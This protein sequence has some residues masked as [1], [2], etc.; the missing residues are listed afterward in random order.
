MLDWTKI[1]NE[2][3]FQNL[4]ND[5]FAWEIDK[6]DFKPG[7]AYIGADGGWDG[8]HDGEYGGVNGTFLFQAKWTSKQDLT[9]AFKSIKSVLPS[10]LEKARDQAVNHVILA[11]NAKLQVGSHIPDLEALNDGHV[12]N[13]FVYDQ[14]KLEQ[15]IDK[16]PWIKY[17]YF[18]QAA[19]PLFSPAEN[20][21]DKSE[22]ELVITKDFFGFK[23]E[24]LQF[25]DFLETNNRILV[26]SAP[27]GCGK[28]RFLHEVT[29]EISE[30]AD[31]PWI[32][33]F[34]RLSL[35]PLDTAFSEELLSDR[36][37][38]LFI[39][40]IDLYPEK[41]P[42]I[43][44]AAKHLDRSRIRIVLTSRTENVDTI[45]KE[46]DRLRINDS[47][48][49]ELESLPAEEQV[50]LLEEVSG[51]SITKEMEKVL[52]GLGDNLHQ[53]V[54]Y[55]V[56]LS[57][58]DSVKAEDI[59]T[60]IIKEQ[61][62]KAGTLQ[63]QGFSENEVN[64]LLV[65]LAANVPFKYS[66]EKSLSLLSSQL[67]KSQEDV[68]RAIKTLEDNGLIRQIG[69]SYRFSTDMKGNILLSQ[70]VSSETLD[71]N[72][73]H[74]WMSIDAK[75]LSY[76]LGIA[77]MHS[78]DAWLHS[79]I[80][81]VV[82][83]L[84]VE[85]GGAE[86]DVSTRGLDW[87]ANF[88]HVVP[89]VVVNCLYILLQKLEDPI[90]RDDLGSILSSLVVQP[91]FNKEILEL[92]RVISNRN[93]D[94][95]YNN[96]EPKELIGDAVSPIKMR[97]ID[98]A[99]QNLALLQEW[100]S[101]DDMS[102]DT[103]ELIISALEEALGGSHKYNHSEG[104][105]ITF[106]HRVLVYGP[107]VEEY[108][109]SAMLVVKKLFKHT[110]NEA[111]IEA[112]KLLSKVGAETHTKE[113]PLWNRI[114][115]DKLE[116]LK[117]IENEILSEDPDI[118]LLSEAEDELFRLW[119]NTDV[120]PELEAKTLELLKVLPKSPELQ[121]YK[122]I[123]NSDFVIKNNADVISEAPD[124]EIWSWLV[125]NHMHRFSATDNDILITVVD[126][127]SK[128]Y[129]SAEDVVLFLQ[130][131]DEKITGTHWGYTPL[132]ETWFSKSKD[133]IIKIISEDNLMQQVP[134]RFVH[135]F[136]MVGSKNIPEYLDEY[137]LSIL[138]KKIVD[139]TELDKL[140]DMIQASDKDPEIYTLWLNDIC[141][142]L[143]ADAKRILINRLPRI[144]EGLSL[145]KKQEMVNILTNV[146][147]SDDEGG[148]AGHADFS[149]HQIERY[150]DYQDLDLVDFKAALFNSL[151]CA[152]RFDYHQKSAASFVL[153]QNIH[154][155]IELI[156]SRLRHKD[157]S[158][159][160]YDALPFD[161]FDDLADYIKSYEEYCLLVEKI[162]EWLTNDLMYSFQV[163][164][165]TSRLHSL[166]D[167]NGKTFNQKYIE[168]KLASK[169]ETDVET[170]IT[171]LHGIVFGL[172]TYGVFITALERTDGTKLYDKAK[173]VL[174]HGVL[175]GSFSGTVG[176]TPKEWIV[177]QSTLEQIIST[178]KPGKT[179]MLFESL[180]NQV[181][182]DI[183]SNLEEAE[184]ILDPKE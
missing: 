85:L 22:Y 16:Y 97:N 109:S 83:S 110:Q 126:E 82:E 43:L 7:N 74:E 44:G 96:Y 19:E 153:E 125:H 61:L 146:L 176:E 65:L 138:E 148:L 39:D 144:Y 36:K 63:S 20:Y 173:N 131:L 81:S 87:L 67:G 42:D 150:L 161:G 71:K 59:N 111:K 15:I 66:D 14:T 23:R 99:I 168:E 1:D 123:S 52:K 77:Y 26:V 91:V 177:K 171:C 21:F 55:G 60:G 105:T 149:V 180:L 156:E 104:V 62:S 179:K 121:I 34:G 90:N 25:S 155:F 84:S 152:P 182:Q 2:K 184:E 72:I 50:K 73:V 57:G 165:L 47:K 137:A 10:E 154:R 46:I 127:L 27:G 147:H 79:L 35:K 140:L 112:T 116:V 8:R 75:Q 128:K 160:A 58:S 4:V 95:R 33:L 86:Q 51:K 178:V 169:N 139:H 32:P 120:Y 130:N 132:V 162:H 31:G 102:K 167:E 49:I 101:E 141:S 38:V 24:M 29:S 106:G 145:Q 122:L 5:I 175:S 124:T 9:E 166:K 118:R 64:K 6:P 143:N 40:N 53:I 11:T 157:T 12:D 37:Y 129:K 107:K 89:E 30:R 170:A 134:H 108:R 172:D 93:T 158:D 103:L 142:K 114:I 181:K 113:G 174:I 76:N 3:T 135:G 159:Y 163:D 164:S 151:I 56:L 28:S 45:Y 54:Q 133:V 48:N 70:L 92:V 18:N 100:S 41:I 88:T 117:H 94:G 78:K 69:K 183:K 136:Q 98:T 68:E 119:G 80:K 17:K 13:L 115:N